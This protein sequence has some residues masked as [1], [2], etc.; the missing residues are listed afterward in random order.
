MRIKRKKPDPKDT[1]F[2]FDPRRALGLVTG[3][4]DE[5]TP[6]VMTAREKADLI[7]AE[8][9]Q[10][11]E[12]IR[13][14]A[15]NEGYT[16]GF[17][18]GVAEWKDSVENAILERQRVLDELEK[19]NGD[20]EK[21]CVDLAI[22]MS[23]KIVRKSVQADP[24]IVLNVLQVALTQIRDRAN[25]QL[26]INKSD[27]ERIRKAQIEVAEW[28]DTLHNISIVEDRRVDPGGVVIE[29]EDG[30]LDARI[31]SQLREIHNALDEAA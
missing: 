29:S 24:D 26:Y 1:A 31:T 30:V 27:I 22:R 9:E 14:V 25:V 16:A 13:T 20:L 6:A 7:Q 2:V 17:A 11:A 28:A 4:P 15:Y 8:A 23:E 19:I 12:T 10:H 5:M 21:I 18:R 3:D